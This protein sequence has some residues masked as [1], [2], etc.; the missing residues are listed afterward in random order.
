MVAT[1]IPKAS[2]ALVEARERG[3]C[4]RCGGVGTDW[5]HRRSRRVRDAHTHCA[6]NGILLCRDCHSW[7]HSKMAAAEQGYRV[8]S[9]ESTP[10]SVPAVRFGRWWVQ[11]CDG[12][13]MCVDPQ[14]VDLSDGT[15]WMEV[16]Q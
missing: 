9:Y 7:A 12:T 5:H 15:P 1:A 11:R 10:V 2:R 16:V 13:A 8:S 4:A 14:S 3:L 6:C